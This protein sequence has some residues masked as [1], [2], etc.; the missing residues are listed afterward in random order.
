MGKMTEKKV[1]LFNITLWKSLFDQLGVDTTNVNMKESVRVISNIRRES[2]VRVE[3]IVEL[4]NNYR[5]DIRQFFVEMGAEMSMAVSILPKSKFK[6]IVF[7]SE[8]IATDNKR[9]PR[10]TDVLDALNTHGVEWDQIFVTQK[11]DAKDDGHG[12]WDMGGSAPA[13]AAAESASAPAVEESTRQRVN[14]STSGEALR[15]AVA[16]SSPLPYSFNAELFKILPR[17]LNVGRIHIGLRSGHAATL[18]QRVAE[19]GN[20]SVANLVDVCNAFRLNINEFFSS[21]YSEKVVMEEKDWQ[22]IEFHNE[23]LR[24]LFVGKDARMNLNELCAQTRFT[25]IRIERYIKSASAMQADDLITL[26]KVCG[27]APSYFWDGAASVAERTIVSDMR[28]DLSA[29]KNAEE[30]MRKENAQ[31]QAKIRH[32]EAMLKMKG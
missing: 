22:P 5:L 20:I 21:S 8:L 1:Y 26:C 12:M 24:G 11:S 25:R 6:P 28:T 17:L 14:E 18:W 16:G 7:N 32:L 30:R 4:C 23:R 31:L 27:V 13:A 29:A 3:A 9:Q 15:D 2:A 10:H 19:T